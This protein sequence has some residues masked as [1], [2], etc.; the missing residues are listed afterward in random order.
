[1]N[2]PHAV[3]ILFVCMGNICRSPTAHGIM[4]ELVRDR[5]LE[6][7]IEIDSAGTL[8]YHEGA[9][10]DARM[11]S[12][13]E[14][15]GHKLT[16]RSRPVKPDDF[17]HFDYVVAMDNVNLRDMKPFMPDQP[18]RAKISL[19]MDHLADPPCAEVPDPY[20]HGATMF[21]YVV[22]VVEKGCEALLDEI[23]GRHQLG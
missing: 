9:L 21:D 4:E 7:R 8:D 5:G 18:F 6:N 16:H 11:R 19:L 14:R 23:V 15:R 12:A 10:P 3:R 13:A 20:S 22:D 2:D 17:H 1:M